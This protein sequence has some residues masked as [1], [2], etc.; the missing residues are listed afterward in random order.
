MS[1]AGWLNF[2]EQPALLI[3]FFVKTDWTAK[4]RPGRISLT[5]SAAVENFSAQ[6][7][8]MNQEYNAK[9]AKQNIFPF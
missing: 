6:L 8:M 3:Q 5:S 2:N 1:W 7:V 9:T 4:F